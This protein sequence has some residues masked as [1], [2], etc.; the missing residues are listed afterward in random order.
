MLNDNVMKGRRRTIRPAPWLELQ[1]HLLE[2]LSPDLVSRSRVELLRD[3]C[4]SNDALVRHMVG[5]LWQ[6]CHR[7]RWPRPLH[8]R[9]M[10]WHI[11]R[12]SLRPRHVVQLEVAVKAYIIILVLQFLP[13]AAPTKGHNHPLLARRSRGSGFP[14]A[15]HQC[16]PQRLEEACVGDILLD[17]HGKGGHAGYH[18]GNVVLQYAV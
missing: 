3:L 8:L 5:R 6:R 2:C 14:A 10:R 12:V 15:G 9:L 11:F 16:R 13:V 17:E 7:R 1:H 18:N 4:C